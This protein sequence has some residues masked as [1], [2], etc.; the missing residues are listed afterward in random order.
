[1]TNQMGHEGRVAI[2]GLGIVSCLGTNL[3][4]VTEALQAGRSGVVLDPLRQEMGFRSALTGQ[5]PELDLASYGLG[6]KQLKTMGDPARFAYAATRDALQD[7]GLELEDLQRVETGIVFGNDSCIKPAAESIQHLQTNRATRKIGSGA[8]FQS[9]NSTVTMNLST[10]LNLSGANWTLSAACASGA[11]SIGQGY[12]LLRTGLQQR[13]LCG[14][15][16]EINWQGMAAFDALGAF[17]TRHDHPTAASR[18]FDR[19]RDG[20]VPSGGAACVVLEDLNLA[21]RRGARI[22][23]EVVGYGFSAD[24]YHLSQANAH[25]GARAIQMALRSAHIDPSQIDYINAHATSTTH[26][27]ANEAQIIQHIFEPCPPVSSTKS[28]TGHECWM[29]GASEVVYSCLMAQG[30]FLAPNINFEEP[31][32][33]TAGLQLVTETRPARLRYFL[34][35]SLGFGGTNASLVIRCHL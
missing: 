14:G 18:P 19:Q 26:G 11:H 34:S 1:M 24:G 30:G 4:Q 3:Q 2:T 16:Q 35:N 32:E 27:D 21:R 15:A 6:R 28:M 22:Y 9:M 13:V 20:L 8:I 12:L 10:L 7:S 25:G 33:Q 31:D 17:S 23:G 29:S 5:R